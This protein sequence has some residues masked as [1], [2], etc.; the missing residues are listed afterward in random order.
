[1]DWISQEEQERRVEVAR[2]FRHSTEMEGGRVS[3][4][5][6][7]DFAAHARGEIDEAELLRRARQRYGLDGS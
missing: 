4:A 7:A 1:M 2:Q 6:Q 5:A 3:D